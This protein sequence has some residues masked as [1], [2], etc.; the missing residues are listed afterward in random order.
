MFA[1]RDLIEILGKLGLGLVNIDH[2]HSH[3]YDYDHVRDQGRL[4]SRITPACSRA[5]R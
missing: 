1:G 5:R 3:D 4:M 2:D